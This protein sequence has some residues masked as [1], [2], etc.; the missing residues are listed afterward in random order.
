M[1]ELQPRSR[2]PT[3]VGAVSTIVAGATFLLGEVNSQRFMLESCRTIHLK[4]KGPLVDLWGPLISPL[5]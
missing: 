1:A 2:G 3:I 4:K 5:A